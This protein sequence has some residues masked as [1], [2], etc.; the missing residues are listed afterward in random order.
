M[1]YTVKELRKAIDS[2]PYISKK[3]AMRCYSK[4]TSQL[5]QHGSSLV[6]LIDAKMV[7]LNTD[8][9][10]RAVNHIVNKLPDVPRCKVCDDPLAYRR[11]YP[12]YC[13]AKCR[14]DCPEYKK[15]LKG[16]IF[17]K[18]GV[19]CGLDLGGRE[20]GI[21][22]AHS[23]DARKNRD[24]TNLKKFGTKNQIRSVQTQKKVQSSINSRY[25]SETEMFRASDRKRRLTMLKRYGVEHYSELPEY[26]E[27]FLIK[28]QELYG[29]DH[30]MQN[31]KIK[32]RLRKTMVKKYGVPY[33]M[34][35]QETFDLQQRSAMKRK[36]I[37][38]NGKVFKDLQG[39]EPLAIKY[40]HRLGFDVKNITSHPKF[41][42]TIHWKDAD[43]KNHVYFP[44]FLLGKNHI[45]EVKSKYTF[46][47]TEKMK[48]ANKRKCLACTDRGYKFTILV[49][50]NEG[51]M[52]HRITRVPK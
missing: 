30:P 48:D 46:N 34:Q 45:V 33:A 6:K 28:S 22:N 44:D 20:R 39:Y 8:D 4:G 10:W 27:R 29:V 3:L 42:P 11:G 19:T 9:V 36:S 21:K 7:S 32:K 5:H 24:S 14:A 13:S 18:Y 15:V 49:F 25:G 47:G 35:S 38:I 50:N 16:A 52:I 17:E 51:E 37:K 43:K 41:S 23:V 40:F 26:R 2:D 31:E 1:I 12:V